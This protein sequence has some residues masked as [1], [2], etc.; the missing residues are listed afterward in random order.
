MYGQ[1]YL[2][3]LIS[4][5]VIVL[6]IGFWLA[7]KASS[8]FNFPGKVFVLKKF[9]INDTPSVESN[10]I[11]EIK[12]RHPGIFSWLLTLLKFDMVTQLLVTNK[13]ISFKSKSF[14]C[15]VNHV[16]SLKSVASASCGFI[17]PVQFIII[18]PIIAILSIGYNLFQRYYNI[19]TMQIDL[20]SNWHR[21]IFTD[22]IPLIGWVLCLAMIVKYFLTK[23]IA[24]SIETNG[25]MRFGLSFKRSVIEK[26]PMDIEIARKAIELLGERIVDS[27]IKAMV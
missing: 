16:V 21:I 24:I 2:I 12:G 18:G 25:G 3:V 26:I 8:Q 20:L 13:E 1:T 17:K 10:I 14:F 22:I 9:K 7:K 6:I 27:H 15:E 4:I 11:I 5:G 19:Y 23:T